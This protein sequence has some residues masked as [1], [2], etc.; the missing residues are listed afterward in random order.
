MSNLLFT[1]AWA[2][3]C[4]SIVLFIAWASTPSQR[5]SPPG[6]LY[7]RIVVAL[8]V[9]GMLIMAIGVWIEVFIWIGAIIIECASILYFVRQLQTKKHLGGT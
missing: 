6:N 3:M 1:F 5:G 4:I 7:R 2:L 8:M 9:L